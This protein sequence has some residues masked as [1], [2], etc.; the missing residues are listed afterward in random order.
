MLQS[1]GTKFDSRDLWLRI[2]CG[3]RAASAASATHPSN[4]LAAHRNSALWRSCSHH[5]LGLLAGDWSGRKRP[6][7][8]TVNPA[9]LAVKSLLSFAQET[10]YLRYNV[11]A[12]VHSLPELDELAQRILTP[13][14][15]WSLI[16]HAPTGRDRVLL[17][18]RYTCGVRRAEAAGLRWCDLQPPRKPD[19]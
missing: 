18:V 13:E 4:N 11:G 6:A 17:E 7:A 16:D 14:D 2:E 8:A 10:G 12:A 1:G 3:F 5:S 9:L 15:V 19:S